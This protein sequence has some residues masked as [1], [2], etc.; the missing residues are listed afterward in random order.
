VSSLLP[1]NEIDLSALNVDFD[2]FDKKEKKEM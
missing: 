2:L 1:N